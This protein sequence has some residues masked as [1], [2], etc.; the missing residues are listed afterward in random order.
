MFRGLTESRATAARAEAPGRPPAAELVQA[1]AEDVRL[2]MS[3]DRRARA[4]GKAELHFLLSVG[5]TVEDRSDRVSLLCEAAR[6]A[7]EVTVGRRPPL[8]RR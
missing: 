2:L 6:L 7:Y 3:A 8:P 4:L 5:L 1:V